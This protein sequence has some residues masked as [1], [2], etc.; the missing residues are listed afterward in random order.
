MSN[1][2]QPTETRVA[3]T[4]LAG[5]VS[6]IALCATLTYVPA[7]P[8]WAS[9]TVPWQPGERLPVVRL[10]TEEHE[11][12]NPNVAGGAQHR[13]AQEEEEAELEEESEQPGS[14]PTP[15]AQRGV[16]IAPSEYS[17]RTASIEDPTGHAMDA[18]YRALAATARGEAHAVTRV[19][20]YGDSS[21]ALDGITQTVRQRLQ[22]RFG[23]AGHGF[24]LASRGTMPYRHRGVRHESEGTWR[25]MEITHLPLSDG[26]YGLGGYQAR[27]ITG[28][29]SFFETVE[30]GPVGRSVG[31]FDVLY[32]QY[33]RGGRLELRVDSGEPIEVDTRGPAD[34]GIRRVEVPDGSHR[35]ELRTVGHGESHVYGV[36]LEREGPGVVYDSLGMVGA[37]ANRF[38][39]FDEAHLRRQLALRDTALVVI[40]YGGND[41]DDDHEPAIYERDFRQVAHLVRQARPEASCLLF[42]PL[43][44]GQ[45]N[46]RGQVE[47]MPAVPRI[48]AAMRAAARAEGCAFFDTFA[49]MGGEGSMGRW[50]RQT[51]RLS[52]GDFRHATPAGYRVVGDLFYQALLEGFATSGSR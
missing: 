22:Q 45:R 43:D 14:E 8:A 19:A 51:P 23:D 48:V 33:P 42:A 37:R 27:S 30:D 41:A 17:G 6:T 32:E 1:Q 15:P 40:G 11:A 2:P 36:V 25:L 9:A 3:L 7:L 52:S 20:H 34:D 13:D 35:L 50:F 29:R 38:L 28:A 10:F 49:A 5:V 18:F 12:S 26:H 16:A 44:Q 31:R 21:I 4:H 46:A 47:T 39:G 24:V